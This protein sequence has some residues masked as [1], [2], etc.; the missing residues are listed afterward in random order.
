MGEGTGKRK[1]PRRAYDMLLSFSLSVLEF[2]DL[3]HIEASG[4]SVDISEAGLG[5]LTDFPLEPGHVIRIKNDNASFMTASVKWIGEMDGR[6][7]AG[8]FLYK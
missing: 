4:K 5:F 8:V 2:T 1:Y 7:R 6:Y 3:K